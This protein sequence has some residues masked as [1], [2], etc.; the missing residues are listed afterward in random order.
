MSK[1]PQRCSIRL[2]DPVGLSMALVVLE[3]SKSLNIKCQDN[4]KGQ[5]AWLH[6]QSRI[7][8]AAETITPLLYIS[9]TK[10]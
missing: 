5:Q 4:N 9:T 2:A 7:I 10:N 6:Q 1:A 8:T 3:F